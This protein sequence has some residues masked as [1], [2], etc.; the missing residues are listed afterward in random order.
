MNPFEMVVLIVAICVAG[1]VLRARLGGSC[2]KGDGGGAGDPA[3]RDENTRLHEELRAL[4]ARVATLE[5]IATDG[6]AP[7]DREIEAL[8]DRP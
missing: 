2:R 5:R 1:S 4:K 6:S 8:R 7:L 3:L